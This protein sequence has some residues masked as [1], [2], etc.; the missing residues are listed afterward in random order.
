VEAVSSGVRESARR[1]ISAL[2]EV[3]GQETIRLL[4]SRLSKE[5]VN[6]VEI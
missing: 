1:C 3:E 4:P 2:A 6:D 5:Q